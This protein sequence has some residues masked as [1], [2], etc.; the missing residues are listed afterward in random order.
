MDIPY[1]HLYHTLVEDNIQHA[2]GKAYHVK[3]R[4]ELDGWNT[5]LFEDF[6]DLAAE[7]FNNV[8]W[9]PDSLVLPELHDYSRSKP[10]P[11]NVAPITTEQ[12]K[13]NLMIIITK[14]SRL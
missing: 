4:E 6:Y 1:L 7:Q 11:L 3:T 8:D 14:W 9:I 10:L 2:F 5:S 13:K 12:F